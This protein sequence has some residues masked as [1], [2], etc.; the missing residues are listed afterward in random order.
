M[1]IKRWAA[2][3]VGE[4]TLNSFGVLVFKQSG[5]DQHP[6]RVITKPNSAPWAPFG[7]AVDS[8]RDLYVANESDGI[9]FVYPPG[10]SS[11]SK[12]LTGAGNPD[13]VAVDRRGTVYVSNCGVWN[14]FCTNGSVLEYANGQTTPS[15]TLYSFRKNEGPTA[16]ALDSANNLYIA[17]N[18]IRAGSRPEGGVLEIR[19]GSSTAKN[20]GILV[21]DAYGMTLD[22]ANDLLLVDRG[23]CNCVDVFLPGNNVPFK[24]ITGFPNPSIVSV[25]INKEST[26]IW[27]TAIM[28]FSLSSAVYGV[29]YPDGQIVDTISTGALSVGVATSPN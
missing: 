7:L 6:L 20:L 22:K 10:A 14:G 26:K 24:Q 25:A 29:T 11:P 9:V 15:K 23:S 5:H 16:V 1:R 19:A 17:F 3:L 21:G 12:T 2:L 18:R 8:D 13:G 4:E 27:V 28:G